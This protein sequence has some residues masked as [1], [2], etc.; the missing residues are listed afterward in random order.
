MSPYRAGPGSG[1]F[2]GYV[3][4]PNRPWI[5]VGST[6]D[7]LGGA[8]SNIIRS[9]YDRKLREQAQREREEQIAYQR[10]RDTIADQRYDAEQQRK[11]S[12][13][14]REFGLKQQAEQHRFIEE[15]GTP[16]TTSFDT[17]P[18]AIDFSR[19]F[20]P[21]VTPAAPTGIGASPIGRAMLGGTQ[22]SVAPVAQQPT[23]PASRL[24]TTP[25]SYDPTRA[26]GY[27]RAM[28]PAILRAEVAGEH[29]AAVADRMMKGRLFAA[30]AAKDLAKY[31]AGLGI[32]TGRGGRI[33]GAMTATALESARN[34]AALGLLDRTNGSY[35]EAERILTTTPEGESL[36][37]LG[38]EPRHLMFAHSKYVGTL[39][40]EAMRLQGGTYGMPPDSAV[41]NVARTRSLAA[42]SAQPVAPP[43]TNLQLN[44]PLPS[45]GASPNDPSLDRGAGTPESGSTIG[46]LPTSTRALT[47]P[48]GPISQASGSPVTLTRE[49]STAMQAEIDRANAQVVKVNNSDLPAAEKAA[50]KAAY[51]RRLQAIARRYRAILPRSSRAGAKP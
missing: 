10:Q 45:S 29:D 28:D 44:S 27:A 21:S 41:A 5:D 18:S 16:A 48:N 35:D 8:V 25:E 49:Q 50:A 14:D 47:P 6:L 38:V 23:A 2:G 19:E 7:A 51:D 42:P 31:K 36:R 43:W 26:A 3:T 46:A 30:Q 20:T 4:P 33:G 12:E 40:H 32:G 11:Q 17:T 15:G 34:N 37:Q 24:S 9:A 22:A 1:L 13:A 39:T